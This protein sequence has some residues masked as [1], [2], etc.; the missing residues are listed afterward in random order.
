MRK[1]NTRVTR[2]ALEWNPQ[3]HKKK[4]HGDE[5]LNLK[6]ERLENQSDKKRQFDRTLLNHPSYLTGYFVAM[7]TV[8]NYPFLLFSLNW[9]VL[10]TLQTNS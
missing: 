1:G 9:G 2:H 5:I 3:G 6:L 7:Y 8:G 4:T 10:L